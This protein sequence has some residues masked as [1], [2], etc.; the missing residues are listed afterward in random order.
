MFLFPNEEKFYKTGRSALRYYMSISLA[1]C[2][3]RFAVEIK[4]RS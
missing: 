2:A 4:T 3:L 1:R